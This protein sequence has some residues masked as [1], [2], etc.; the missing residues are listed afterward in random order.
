MITNK[1]IEQ[2]FPKGKLTIVAARPAMG[3]TSLIT[4]LAISV[5]NI[6]YNSLFFSL[7]MTEAQLIR[8][9]KLQLDEEQY[10]KIDGMIYIDDTPSVK[11]SEIRKRL[12]Q[13]S[14]DYIFLDFIQLINGETNGER[15]EELTHIIK[16]LKQIAKE[17]NI[18]V[19]ATSQLSRYAG[20]RGELPPDFGSRPNL[21]N[22][23]IPNEVLN[24]VNIIFIHRLDYYRKYLNSEIRMDGKVEFITYNGSDMVITP[25]RFIHQKTE[26]T[27]W[28]TWENMK[29]EILNTNH[30]LISLDK[31]D[32]EYFQENNQEN[33][34]VFDSSTNDTSENRLDRLV[35]SLKDQIRSVTTCTKKM[36]VIIQNPVSAPLTMNE[37]DSG[38]K[39][40]ELDP[41]EDDYKDIT[42]WWGVSV[43][44]DTTTRIMCAIQL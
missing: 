30:W 9:M 44:N 34:M 29:E 13:L 4:S 24:D 21:H 40:L 28:V 7:E 3:K 10:N 19:I 18:P 42:I 23:H 17:F 32:I 22:L 43:R 5:A 27:E 14:V 31:A 38:K 37:M 35:Y 12:E 25:L 20:V 11:L 41:N 16:T 33:I 36:L 2:N 1:F 8:R 39:L 6:G 15:D 26:F